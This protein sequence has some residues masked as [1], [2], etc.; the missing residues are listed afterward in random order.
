MGL[1]LWHGGSITFPTIDTIVKAGLAV[2]LHGW[3]PEAFEG[4]AWIQ[5]VY[6]HCP[7]HKCAHKLDRRAFKSGHG[8]DKAAFYLSYNYQNKAA[9]GFHIYAINQTMDERLC[10]NDLVPFHSHPVCERAEFKC[11]R[12]CD[13][14]VES[15]RCVFK[16]LG[17]LLY[18]S[19]AADELDGVDL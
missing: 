8:T 11:L 12:D 6:A 10:F 17:C 2:L 5:M 13:H 9:A 1:V 14:A 19:D 3:P 7:G 15:Y 16:G 4:L 18:T